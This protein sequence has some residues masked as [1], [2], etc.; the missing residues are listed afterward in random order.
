MA[1]KELQVASWF[2]ASNLNQ[3]AQPPLSHQHILDFQRE[4]ASVLEQKYANHWHPETPERGHAYRS[5]LI[6]Q[7]RLIDDV[8]VAAARRANVPGITQRL[9]KL[10]S[11][12]MWIDPRNVTVQY[13]PSNRQQV[14]YDGNIPSAPASPPKN[15]TFPNRLPIVDPATGT[16]VI[17]PA[18]T[19]V[20]TAD[21][22]HSK[23]LFIQQQPPQF[24]HHQIPAA[25]QFCRLPGDLTNN[26]VAAASAGNFL[27][28]AGDSH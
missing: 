1:L 25:A 21:N 2:L 3:N 23:T 16:N 9:S 27:L 24:A 19:Y 18:A 17:L 13:L 6:D 14:L 5:V 8:I 10:P 15:Q 7:T 20:Q 28:R 12:L 4:L 11:L 26:A 22:R